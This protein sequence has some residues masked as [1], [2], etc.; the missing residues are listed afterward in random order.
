LVFVPL[1]L[2]ERSLSISE[3]GPA[4]L[5]IWSVLSYSAYWLYSVCL[6]ARYGQ[7]IGKMITRVKVLDRSERRVPTIREAFLRD[8]GYILLS[9]CSL[10]SFVY[11]VCTGRYVPGKETASLSEAVLAWAGCAWYLLEVITMLTNDKR[12]AV[13]DFIA[14]TVVVRPGA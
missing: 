7:T 5:I 13:H 10:V 8:T 12:R 9:I 1:G 2:L 6:H 4:I 14:G 3:R 11:V